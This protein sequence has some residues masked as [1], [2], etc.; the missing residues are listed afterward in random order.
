VKSYKKREGIIKKIELGNFKPGLF[1]PG[2]Q[3][4]LNKYLPVERTLRQSMA[5]A[6]A[7][8]QRENQQN[9]TKDNT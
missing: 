5:R 6:N 1:L 7:A 9:D 4:Q 8:P 3:L 2:K